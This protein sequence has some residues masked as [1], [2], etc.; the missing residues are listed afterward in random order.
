MFTTKIQ[1][2]LLFTVALFLNACEGDGQSTSEAEEGNVNIPELLKRPEALQN[3]MEWDQTQSGYMQM[4]S[5][6]RLE[7]PEAIE[8]RITLAKIF[9]N[10]ARVTG[11]HGHYYP[12][13]LQMVNE[14]IELNHQ[15]PKDPNLEFDALSTKAGV[16]LSQHEFKDALATAKQAVSINPYNAQVYG[17]V[18]DANVE[19]GNYEEAVAAA[20]KMNE[21]RPDLRSYSRV[22]YLREIHG[23]IDGAIEAMERA[24]TA[25]AP[26]FESTAWARLTLGELFHRY[27]QPEKAAQQ[28][29]AILRERPNY[30]FAI[31]AQAKLAMDAGDEA[32]AERLLNEARGIIPEVGYYIQLAELYKKQ[33][34]EEEGKAIE[35]EI[36]AMLQDDVDSGHNMDMEYAAL[37]RDHFEDYDKALEYIRK[38]YENRPNNIDVNRM[39]ADIYLKRG[40]LDK[41]REHLTK[42][43]ITDSKHPELARIRDEM[44]K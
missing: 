40:E 2:L 30:P 37:Y 10:E 32:E 3:A 11:E 22:S 9:V 43:E 24:V 38:E 1:V 21:I 44:A 8:P 39:L 5:K 13:A 18:V 27:G 15:G 23:D 31:A 35:Q 7:D 26:G 19:L 20:D 34:R 25:G 42:A 41:A 16:Q 6:L 14:A 4:S 17:A 12:A 29:A 28:Y 36:M 33:G